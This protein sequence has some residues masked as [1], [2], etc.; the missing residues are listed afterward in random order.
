ESMFSRH[1][2]RDSDDTV[3]GFHLSS[4]GLFAFTCGVLLAGT[5]ARLRPSAL[6]APLAKASKVSGDLP[7]LFIPTLL[8]I[9]TVL[10]IVAFMPVAALPSASAVI[11]AGKQSA[12][13]AVCILCWSAWQ[14][15]RVASFYLWIA[16][17]FVLPILTV[18]TT[19][20][21]G[22]GIMM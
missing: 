18:V 3:S 7:P 12:L 6:S 9:G 22:Y 1:M 11:S 14:E 10:W 20:F 13:L 4:L 19:G 21:V 2:L 17:A 16:A 5:G 8:T 15:N